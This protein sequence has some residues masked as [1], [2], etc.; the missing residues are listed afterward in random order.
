MTRSGNAALARR[1]TSEQILMT[2]PN[3]QPSIIMVKSN[4]APK[5]HCHLSHHA[6]V[7]VTLEGQLLAVTQQHLTE[8]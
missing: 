7:T 8:H 2:Y 1:H 5:G 6:A 3:K 4:N